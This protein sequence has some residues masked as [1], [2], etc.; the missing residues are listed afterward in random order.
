MIKADEIQRQKKAK[1]CFGLLRSIVIHGVLHGRSGHSDKCLLIPLR[2]AGGNTDIWMSARASALGP[3][4]N[5]QADI[6][7][8][9]FYF[10]AYYCVLCIYAFFLPFPQASIPQGGNIR[11]T[12]TSPVHNKSSV[13]FYTFPASPLIVLMVVSY[14]SVH[15]RVRAGGYKQRGKHVTYL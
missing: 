3:G 4:N 15:A 12:S 10:P 9:S 7:P 6:I 11:P 2:V 13:D 1:T 8:G 14:Y 5:N